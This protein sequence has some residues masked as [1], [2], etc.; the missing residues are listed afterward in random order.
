MGGFAE[1]HHRTQDGKARET[2]KYS[3]ASRRPSC[4]VCLSQHQ[5]G[6]NI[7]IC[8]EQRGPVNYVSR[9]SIYPTGRA[10]SPAFAL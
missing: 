3:E 8:M 2:W 9:L 10:L 4:D 5:S 6:F 1:Y 7:A